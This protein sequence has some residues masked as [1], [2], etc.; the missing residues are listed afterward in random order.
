MHQ[1]VLASQ[2]PRRK[3]LLEKAG[4]KFHTFT[5]EVSEILK[6]NLIL[7][8]ALKELVCRKAQAALD[9]AKLLKLKDFLVLTGDTVV[10]LEDEVLGKPKNALQAEEFLNRL[11]NKTHSVITA[12]CLVAEGSQDFVTGYCVTRV[13]FR[14][15]EAEEIQEYVQ[16]G[17][18]MDKA[19]AYAIQGA[20]KK[21]V[22][23][24]DGPLDNVVGLPIE[25]VERLMKENGWIVD[26]QE[27]GN[28]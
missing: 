23:S 26:R 16:S 1:L 24:V 10:V 4:F 21:F 5:I 9:S 7:E 22:V 19:G 28:N 20:A 12:V 3:E 17:E 2:S 6:K 27:L 14:E 11:S 25:L 13:K 8:E 18:P 15:L